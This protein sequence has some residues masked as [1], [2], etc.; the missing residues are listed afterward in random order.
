MKLVPSGKRAAWTH[1]AVWRPSS[2][3][4]GSRIRPIPEPTPGRSRT[5]QGRARYS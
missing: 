5:N 1:G 4:C 3:G 2:A